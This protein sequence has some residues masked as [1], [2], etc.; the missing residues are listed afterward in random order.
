M[1]VNE[2][3]KLVKCKHRNTYV[4]TL[5]YAGF[6]KWGGFRQSPA[7]KVAQVPKKLM[8]GGGGGGGGEDSDTFFPERH[9]RQLSG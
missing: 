5:A 1:D 6:Y 8:S 4:G 7:S 9:Q 3:E 2:N